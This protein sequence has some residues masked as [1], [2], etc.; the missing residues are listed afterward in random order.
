MDIDN[1]LE[2]KIKKGYVYFVYSNVLNKIYVGET[3]T[4]NRINIYNSIIQENDSNIRIR[5]YNFYTKKNTI[6]YELAGDLVDKNNNFKIIYLES[7]FHKHLEKTYILWLYKR[8]VYLYNKKIYKQHEYEDIEVDM[9][10]ISKLKIKTDNLKIRKMLIL[11]SY[12]YRPE[13]FDF[14]YKLLEEIEKKK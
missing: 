4:I 12:L 6:N 2:D 3:T 9:N 14:F 11:N 8:G 5:L 10:L 13:E 1:Y 7:K